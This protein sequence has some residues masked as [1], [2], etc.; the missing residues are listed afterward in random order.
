[1]GAY[2]RFG[3]TEISAGFFFV[4]AV[5]MYLDTECIIIMFVISAAVH[6]LAHVIVVKLAGG[7]I[8]R[9][10]LKATGAEIKYEYPSVRTD[11]SEVAICL[12]GP[13]ANILLAVISATINTHLQSTELHTFAGVNLTLG[14]FNL[15]PVKM[16]D[17]GGVLR[18][19][20][21]IVFG[22]EVIILD[23]LHY[24]TI[25]VLLAICV[26]LALDYGFNLS[27]FLVAIWMI[28]GIFRE[29]RT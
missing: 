3:R 25:I 22:R 18:G 7:S 27:L 4:L 5:M 16:L 11:A 9:L 23:V 21:R 24:G 6:E 1:V 14:L 13:A 2:I 28:T 19:L 10:L 15:L 17:G 26:V 29:N 20:C 12:V 8:D